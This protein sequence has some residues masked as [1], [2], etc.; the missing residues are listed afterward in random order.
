MSAAQEQAYQP[1]E[2]NQET[3]RNIWKTIKEKLVAKFFP[4]ENKFENNAPLNFSELQRAMK[5]LKHLKSFSTSIQFE[6]QV[7]SEAKEQVLESIKMLESGINTMSK[8]DLEKFIKYG[9][10]VLQV[11]MNESLTNGGK[12]SGDSSEDNG[13][14]TAGEFISEAI[15]TLKTKWSN[16]N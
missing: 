15:A 5:L 4:Q 16:K 6:T 10:E 7:P 9:Q 11:Y 3:G 14:L 2:L 12:Q 13:N 1:E 8:G